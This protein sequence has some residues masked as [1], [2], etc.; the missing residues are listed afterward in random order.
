MISFS[1]IKETF[2]NA[3][4]PQRCLVC[5]KLSELESF[6]CKDCEGKL[7]PIYD[8]ICNRCGRE[9]KNCDC[10]NFIYHFDGMVAPF[11]N[12]GHAKDSFYDFKFGS[13]FY[14]ADYFAQMMAK[15]FNEHFSDVEIDLISY[16]PLSKSELKERM[17]DKCEILATKVAT[18]LNLPLVKVISKREMVSTQHNLSCDDRFDNARDAYRVIKNVKNKNILLIDDIK[19][20]GATLDSCAREL[21]FAGAN[22]VYC[23]TALSGQ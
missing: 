22:K 7:T 2:I 19:T 1:K 3:L 8:E 12:E 6:F 18:I 4:F 16:V 5:G 11:I 20:T 9:V 21:K 14:G 10:N 15:A 13:S 23:L 17:F